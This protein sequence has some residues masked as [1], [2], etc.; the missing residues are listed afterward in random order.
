MELEQLIQPYIDNESLIGLAVAIIKDDEVIYS[1]GFGRRD[2]ES[3]LGV[4]PSTLFAFGSVCKTICATLIMR[5]VEEGKLELDRPII[6]YLPKL[7][8]SNQELGDKI[9]LKHILS[10]TTGLPSSGK[11]QGPRDPDSLG[12]FVHEQIPYYSFVA[13]PGALHLYSNTV[14]CIA[15]H[16]AEVVTGRFYD[17]LIQDYIFG[18]L[19]M[20]SSFDPS[21]I[22][23]FAPALSHSKDTAGNFHIIHQLSYN[24]SGNPSSFAYGSVS[25][26]ANLAIM[27]LNQ[28][29]F[30]GQQFLKPSTIK[31]MLNPEGHRHI[32]GIAN[33][34]EHIYR[35]YGLGFW[36]GVYKDHFFAGHEGRQQSYLSCLHLFPEQKTGVILQTNYEDY[37]ALRNILVNLYDQILDLP[38]LGVVHLP[39]PQTTEPSLQ[40]EPY[41]GT[42]LNHSLGLVTFYVENDSLILN[43]NGQITALVSI[44]DHSFYGELGEHWRVSIKFLKD[45]QKP[46]KQVMVSG[47]PYL[48]IQDNPNFKPDPAQW[49][50]FEGIYKDPSNPDLKTLLE[51]KVREDTL[52]ITDDDSET[53]CRPFSESFFLSDYGTVA[54]RKTKA[55]FYILVW[56]EA[57]PYFPINV[58][59]WKKH[60]VVNYL[61]TPY[62][63]M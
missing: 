48:Y 46:L 37:D 53:V 41:T 43:L 20:K 14:F 54:F 57:A 21:V 10:H 32:L 12:R 36:L 15:G 40:L 19:E 24:V 17:D 8:F 26:L 28:G 2:V 13:E 60:K 58:T 47:E 63:N 35:D 61:F 62:S 45:L 50:N 9:T 44:G 3:H 25:D 56:G 33:P 31:T 59:A 22:A 42:Y 16:V 30:K 23:T 34:L 18:P 11:S 38:K 4:T 7:K 51:V 55:G 27:F 5:L 6:Q 49:K 29:T 39:K 1:K 52:V